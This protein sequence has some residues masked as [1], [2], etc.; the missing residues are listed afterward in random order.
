MASWIL[1]H[2]ENPE[3]SMIQQSKLMYKVFVR[4]WFKNLGGLF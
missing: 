3:K 4:W 2:F 1:T